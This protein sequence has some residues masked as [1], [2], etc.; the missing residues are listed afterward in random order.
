MKIK[1]NKL[2]KK[3]IRTKIL[4]K[5]KNFNKRKNEIKF[6]KI[7]NIL[8]KEKFFNKKIGG[9]FPIN[10]ELDDLNLLKQ[11]EQKGYLIC[12]PVIRKNHQMYFSKWSYGDPLKI[13]D[14]GI[15]EPVV[16]KKVLPDIFLVPMVAF[17]FKRN[18]LGYGGGY[19]DTFIKKIN[20]IKKNI[21]IGLAFSFQ[22]IKKI[23]M[24][25]HDQS[26]DYV[27]TDKYI[28]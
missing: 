4:D 20:K 24:S 21:K 23:P 3:E 6:K 11:F 17:D 8:L 22:K 1:F 9:Y 2:K 16:K 25:K 7:F 27:V 10:C 15:P 18:R 28:L 14:L 26:L 5:R 12:L 13:N 19:Y